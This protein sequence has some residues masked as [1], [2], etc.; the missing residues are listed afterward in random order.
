MTGRAFV[1]PGDLASTKQRLGITEAQGPAWDAYAK[2]VQDTVASLQTSHA[3]MDASGMHDDTSGQAMMTQMHD[4]HREA[5][6]TLRAA[7]DQLVATLDD[8]QKQK[9]QELLP[10]L[11]SS[12]RGMM[13]PM[14]MMGMGMMS[15]GDMHE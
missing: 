1:G 5:F 13:A 3:R 14:G 2:V 11:A 8:T 4:Q 9:A 15:M 12:G 10:G 6:K 7:T